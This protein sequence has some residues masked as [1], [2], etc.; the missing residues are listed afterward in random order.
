MPAAVARSLSP[1]PIGR[2]GVVDPDIVTEVDAAKVKMALAAA[3]SGTGTLTQI[4]E[5]YEI[6]AAHG[7]TATKLELMKLLR[8]RL[9]MNAEEIAANRKSA[10]R[11]LAGTIGLGMLA[12][13]C[14]HYVLVAIGQR[15]PG[16]AQ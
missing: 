5:A 10:V 9:S 15:T 4:A 8:S 1:F 6:A 12:G 14:T 7:M 11:R 2:V 16:A 13:I 3:R